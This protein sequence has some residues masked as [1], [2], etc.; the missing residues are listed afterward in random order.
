MRLSPAQEARLHRRKFR[1]RP[2][3]VDVPL[4]E[5]DDGIVS[6]TPVVPD[7]ID[8]AAALL[9]WLD[10]APSDDDH[11]ARATAARA[12]NDARPRP[13]KTVT[14]AVNGILD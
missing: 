12:F 7:G 11:L 8:T 4:P 2:E 1:N 6:V 14:E 5:P 13:W 3:D 9:D 10:S